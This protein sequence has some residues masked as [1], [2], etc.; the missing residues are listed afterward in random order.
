MRRTKPSK[1]QYQVMIA[2]DDSKSM[3]ESKSVNLAFET[4]ALISR[5]LTQLEVGQISIVSFGEST[6]LLHPF[7][8][9]FTSEAGVS[10]FSHFG[11][12]Q[13]VTNVKT[14]VENS[15]SIFEN[16]RNTFK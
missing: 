6:R 13:T 15:L 10:V 16:A 1:R 7:E 9:P 8:Q 11:F 3:S 2:L 14:L 5:A 12:Q 4:V